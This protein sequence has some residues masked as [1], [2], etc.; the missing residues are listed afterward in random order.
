MKIPSTLFLSVFVGNFL[1][2]CVNN[3]STLSENTKSNQAVFDLNSA[4]K[5]IQE[6]TNR[7]TASHIS[8]DT[9]YLNNIFSIDAKSYPPNSD[10]VVGRADIAKLNFDWVNY[11]IHEFKE[12][13]ISFYGN[14]EYLIDE[15]TYYLRYGDEHTI[16][17]G[18]YINIW[19]KESSDW[20][21]VSN[22]W[23]TSLPA[24]AAE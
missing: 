22:I 11:G 9:A 17:E 20:K 16:D 21:I 12:T 3:T 19:K 6:K 1:I 7:F 18:K 5:L 14:E 10:A 23:N 15:G 4:K 2:G 13:S 8:K 24:S